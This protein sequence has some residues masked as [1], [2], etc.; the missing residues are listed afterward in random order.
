MDT[1]TELCL[2]LFVVTLT[3]AGRMMPPTF[4][5]FAHSWQEWMNITL[6]NL[7]RWVNT[8]AACC[9]IYG[10]NGHSSNHQ[11]SC[12]T[13]LIK[14]FS[15]T[16]FKT[17]KVILSLKCAQPLITVMTTK[18]K[19]IS[20]LSRRQKLEQRVLVQGISTICA[21][22]VVPLDQRWDCYVYE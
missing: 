6:M 19:D 14:V 20:L 4:V 11:S 13:L 21:V 16:Y 17:D 8:S 3:A 22:F 5:Y 7:R 12:Y 1:F 10:A 9:Q 18:F 2:C 15:F